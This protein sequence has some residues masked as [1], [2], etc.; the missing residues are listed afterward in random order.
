MKS[1]TPAVKAFAIPVAVYF[2]ADIGADIEDSSAGEEEGEALEDSPK[3][4]I[5]AIATP[6]RSRPSSK[7]SSK[8]K[9]HHEKV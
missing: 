4:K 6:G 2:A 1:F 5:P 7:A 9:T 8:A 3:A